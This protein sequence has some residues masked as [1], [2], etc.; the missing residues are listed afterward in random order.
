MGKIAFLFAGQGSQYPGMAKDLFENISAVH[1]FYGV[2]EAIRPGTLLQMFSGTEEELKKTEN[3]QP[4]LFLADLAGA[5]GLMENGIQ[6][7]V[8][9]GFSLGEIVGLTV[10][11]ILERQQAFKL[12]CQRGRYMQK[13]SEDVDGSMIAVLRMDKDKLQKL[14]KEL[15]VYPVNYNCPG[16]I[17]VSGES[18]KIESLKEKLT[19]QKVRFVDIPVGGP[20][21][22]PFMEKA[23]ES[24]RKDFKEGKSYN[25][26]KSSIPLYANKTAKPY[27]NDEEEMINTISDQVCNSVRWEETL[28]NMAKDGVDTFIECGP[29]KTLS[30]F[31]KRTVEG[32][33]I[34]SINDM[35][36]LQNVI[37][38]LKKDA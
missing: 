15:E 6:P 29:G 34:Y 8:V 21:H 32:A 28:L 2:A 27:S 13:L 1:D 7:D 9:A 12:V 26:K 25:L 23:A 37:R 38:E 3:T 4:C 35:D 33:K 17:V 19:E 20:F 11:G 5:I 22:T 24:I 31:V 10:S 14:C 16:Q 30:G 36:S 18:R